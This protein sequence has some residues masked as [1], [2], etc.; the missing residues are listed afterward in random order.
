MSGTVPDLQVT[1]RWYNLL[2]GQVG[3]LPKLAERT[4]EGCLEE[5]LP[6]KKSGRSGWRKD[7]TTLGPHHLKQGG[8]S[9]WTGARD[10]APEE[11][12]ASS[13]CQHMLM[14]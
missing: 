10:R 6:G 3:R 8:S 4:K 1:T 14:S 7:H 11:G 12:Q 9:L 5:K 13:S 2:G